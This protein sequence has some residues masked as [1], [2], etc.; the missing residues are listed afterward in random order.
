MLTILQACLSSPY[1]VHVPSRYPSAKQ[2]DPP[3]PS[4]FT[5]VMASFNPVEPS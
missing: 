4:D 1:S 3:P 2:H 5:L